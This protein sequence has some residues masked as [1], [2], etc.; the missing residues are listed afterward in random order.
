MSK[1]VLQNP[2]DEKNDRVV[3]HCQRGPRDNRKRFIKTSTR[4]REA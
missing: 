2:V 4:R 1:G 3:L